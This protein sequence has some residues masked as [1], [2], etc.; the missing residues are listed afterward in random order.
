MQLSNVYLP[1]KKISRRND[2]KYFL[3]A[4]T[5]SGREAFI[6]EGEQTVE[7]KPPAR[8]RK[9]RRRQYWRKQNKRKGEERRGQ[10]VS[11]CQ[12]KEF[13]YPKILVLL[14]QSLYSIEL[15]SN[16]M[17]AFKRG[18]KILFD[19]VVNRRSRR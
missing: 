9:K 15:A 4:I 6:G 17:R 14:E 13:R 19:G 2:A 5:F 10:V 3:L 16:F 12:Q 11:F 7:K 8:K 18:G 1:N